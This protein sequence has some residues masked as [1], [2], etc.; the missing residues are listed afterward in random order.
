MLNLLEACNTYP[1]CDSS[2]VIHMHMV[3]KKGDMIVILN[4]KN[5]IILTRIVIGWR[6]C[7][8]YQ[9]LNQYKMLEMLAR[10]A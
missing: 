6:M 5:E 3:S 10:K 7:I 9:R 8:D 4:E 2:W 1:I